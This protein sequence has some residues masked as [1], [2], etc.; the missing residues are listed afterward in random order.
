[1]V[2]VASGRPDGC[3]GV[4]NIVAN[5]DGEYLVVAKY[6]AQVDL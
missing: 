3:T 5:A 6:G 2:D 1:M 4:S